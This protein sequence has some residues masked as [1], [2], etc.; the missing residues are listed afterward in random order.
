MYDV[1]CKLM[2]ESDAATKGQV[3][4]RFGGEPFDLGEVT[5]GEVI[6]VNGQLEA[7]SSWI[8][9]AAVLECYVYTTNGSGLPWTVYIKDF[10]V[11]GISNTLS[12]IS[13][14][15]TVTTYNVGDTVMTDDITVTATYSNGST[16][17]VTSL[18]TIDTSGV[19]NTADGTCNITVSYT[20]NSVTKTTTIPIIIGAGG[21][22]DEWDDSTTVTAAW[23]TNEGV[24]DDIKITERYIADQTY[25]V[26]CKLMVESSGNASGAIVLRLGGV[27]H[28]IDS[29]VVGEAINIDAQKKANASWTTGDLK[30]NVY[31]TNGTGLPWTVYI[32]DLAINA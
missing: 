1:S 32:K 5:F 9:D 10:A 23:K 14:T 15:K 16:A 22:S 17:D 24:F 25:N 3:V 20:E 7:N 11:G 6:N 18:A 13:A 8:V 12:S 2:V 30:P 29:F 4:L 28:T 21:G 26:K 31:T 27:T 19:D